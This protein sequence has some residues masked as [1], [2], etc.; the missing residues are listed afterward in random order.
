MT[1]KERAER[2]RELEGKSRP[3]LIECVLDAEEAVEKRNEKLRRTTYF[4]D[5][6][7]LEKVGDAL[8]NVMACEPSE[9]DMKNGREALK[10]LRKIT[11]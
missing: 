7:F 9:E 2:R 11:S 5:R 8:E 3:S 10:I 6:E 4:Q 1:K